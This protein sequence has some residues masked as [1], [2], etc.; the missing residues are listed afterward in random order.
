[1]VYYIFIEYA[2]KNIHSF[3]NLKKP[4]KN[5]V[6]DE[7]KAKYEYWSHFKI[8]HFIVA[9]NFIKLACNVV[10][11]HMHIFW[12]YPSLNVHCYTFLSFLKWGIP[13]FRDSHLSWYRRITVM[14]CIFTWS[15]KLTCWMSGP[16]CSMQRF[17]LLNMIG[18]Q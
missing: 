17:G 13:A 4:F 8:K 2:R 18:S 11:S 9:I 7:N 14:V 6:E 3:M 16:E 10:F 12:S 1:M 5:H 15:C